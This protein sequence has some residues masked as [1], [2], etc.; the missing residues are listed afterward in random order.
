MKVAKISMNVLFTCPMKVDL[1]YFLKSSLMVTRKRPVIASFI[2][3]I[4]SFSILCA[5]QF[6]RA[7]SRSPGVIVLFNVGI[8][9]VGPGRITGVA[10]YCL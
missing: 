8:S 7:T 2:F 1:M 10:E 4:L 9:G 3:D 5:C 6:R